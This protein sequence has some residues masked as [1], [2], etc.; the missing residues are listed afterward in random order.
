MN[1]LN[2]QFLYECIFKSIVELKLT[3]YLKKFIGYI[4]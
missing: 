4:F 3:V 2:Y 1:H